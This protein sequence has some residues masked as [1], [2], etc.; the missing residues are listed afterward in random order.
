MGRVRMGVW[1]VSRYGNLCSLLTS[2]AGQGKPF[3]PKG[4]G[5]GDIKFIRVILLLMPGRPVLIMVDL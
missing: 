5:G 3:W 4:L 2:N 1:T